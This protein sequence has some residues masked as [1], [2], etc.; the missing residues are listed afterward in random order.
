MRAAVQQLRQAILTGEKPCSS[1]FERLVSLRT[2][3][4]LWADYLATITD[5]REGVQWLSWGG[6]DPLHEYLTS[7]HALFTQLEAEVDRLPAEAET[8]GT[9]PAERGATWTYLTTDQPFGTA[10]ERI[11]RGLVRKLN[12]SRAR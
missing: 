7:V 4:D 5:L 8:S 10:T 12:V 9:D 2:I 1:D 11:M 6:R 3:D